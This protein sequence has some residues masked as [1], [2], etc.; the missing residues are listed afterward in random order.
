MIPT[1][2]IAICWA[3]FT[4]YWGISAVKVK[5]DIRR[6]GAWWKSV[7]WRLL[8]ALA[9]ILVIRFPP[10]RR[11]I[12]TSV[13]RFA[14]SSLPVRVVGAALCT[15]GIAF[16]IWARANLGANWSEKPSVKEGHELVTSGPYQLVRHPIYFGMLVGLLGTTFVSGIPGLIVFLFLGVV[17]VNRI[18]V[19][20]RL[21]VGLFPDKYPEYRKR[22]KTLIPYIV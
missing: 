16:A 1:D 2:V 7:A 17:F 3:V 12:Q 22:T 20:E 6:R 9:V 5:K 14:I 8:L 4:V 18:R 19:E 21:T 10:V 15:A 11:V 13:Y